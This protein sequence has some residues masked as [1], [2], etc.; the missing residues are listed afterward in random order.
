MKF[1]DDMKTKVSGCFRLIFIKKRSLQ[2]NCCW[3][4]CPVSWLDEFGQVL[5]VDL[6][7]IRS[8][9]LVDHYVS[10]TFASQFR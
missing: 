9:S 3:Y 7:K 1:P 8:L 10:K 6:Q 5:E 4:A 2:V